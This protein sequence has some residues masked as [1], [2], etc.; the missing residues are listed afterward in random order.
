MGVL[1]QVVTGPAGFRESAAG[2]KSDI[3]LFRGPRSGRC[4]NLHAEHADEGGSSP[5]PFDHVVL[6]G[7]QAARMLASGCTAILHRPVVHGLKV[8]LYKALHNPFC[9]TTWNV[10]C[11]PTALPYG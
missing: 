9:L 1:Q 10:S 6:S 5:I 3:L 7:R 4:C 8:G 2:A 11:L